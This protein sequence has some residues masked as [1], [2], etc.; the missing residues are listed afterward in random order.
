M[1]ITQGL[2]R[3][4]QVHR[5]G[6]ATICGSRRRTWEETGQRVARLAGALRSLGLGREG[7]V[8]ILSLNSD[9]FLETLY[10]VP[11]A[12]G[13]VVPV[14]VRLAPPEIVDVLNDS[15]SEILIVDDAFQA[16][17][18]ALRGRMDTVSTTIFA[19]DGPAPEG[20]VSYEEIL[21]AAE[22]SGDDVAGIFYTGGTPGGM[23][24]R[25]SRRDV[26]RSGSLGKGRAA[27]LRLGAAVGVVVRDALIAV[28]DIRAAQAE[29]GALEPD[30]SAQCLTQLLVAHIHQSFSV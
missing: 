19:G 22:R 26:R 15:G 3:A 11:W 16:L 8:A 25:E 21:A 4:I 12:G 13:I 29:G 20:T 27:P 10:A 17:L 30:Q 28:R 2:K 7:R 9:R 5:H 14:N 1:S 24:R 6:T 18:P 23:P